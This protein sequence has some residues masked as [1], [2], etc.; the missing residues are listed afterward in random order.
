MNGSLV[1]VPTYKALMLPVLQAVVGRGGS[2]S[3]SEINKDVVEALAL[4][5]NVLARTNKNGDSQFKVNVSWARSYCKN[6]GLLEVTE[7]GLYRVTARGHEIL[8]LSDD[9]A[10]KRLAILVRDVKRASSDK[11]TRARRQTSEGVV[12]DSET[13][14]GSGNSGDGESEDGGSKALSDAVPT[15]KALMLPVL[16]VVV[17]RGGSASASEIND[18]VVEALA[19]SENVLALTNK[20]GR[21]KIKN[22]ISWAYSRCKDGGVLESAEH[23]RYRV[24]ALGRGI[25]ALG[26]DEAQK[27]LMDI[28]LAVTRA[29]R[30]RS[31]GARQT[32][33]E[34]AVSET[35]SGNVDSGDGESEDGDSEALLDEV[36]T[37]KAL[38]LPVLQAVD[39]C[40]GSVS[41][42]DIYE[43]VKS[44]LAPTEDVLARTNKNGR[45]QFKANVSWAY[46]YCK[47]SGLLEVTESGLYR[48]TA[49]GREILALSDDE[50]QKRLIDV[51]RAVRRAVAAR[52]DRSARTREGVREGAVGN[53]ETPSGSGVSGDGEFEGEGSKKLSDEVPAYRGRGILALDADEAQKRLMDID[54]VVT[55]AKRERSTRARQKTS[56][57]VVG[58]SETTDT[59]W[60]LA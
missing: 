31:V 39:R 60:D 48:V 49:R 30:D 28:D 42:S 11:S 10:Q 38:M 33:S 40:G 3:V 13:L 58:D 54:P 12:G 41:A 19:L 9:E 29:K 1:E 43:A 32:T 35:P 25:L 23:G 20:N 15:Y 45:G 4:S 46:S 17:G 37:Y 36:P 52:R 50:A 8:A 5:E 18:D 16:Q 34:G 24:T 47:K 6:S 44:V 55:Q 26:D 59:Q 21:S 22:R 56:E 51:D 2:A 7:S 14:S 53:S 57:G 27:R